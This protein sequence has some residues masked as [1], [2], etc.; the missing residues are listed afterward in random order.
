[1]SS[2]ERDQRL[3]QLREKA[4]E[5][6][7]RI[8][9]RLE[10]LPP[11]GESRDGNYVDYDGLY[12]WISRER[13]QEVDHRLTLDEDELMYWI[14]SGITSGMALKYEVQHRIP[15]Q[16]FRRVWFDYQLELLEKLNPAW[17]ARRRREQEEILARSPYLDQ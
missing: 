11:F 5:L 12:R 6:A 9:I 1:V 4:G 2:D 7:Q 10:S 15:G 17:S 14:F 16:D 3:A 8:G 13:G